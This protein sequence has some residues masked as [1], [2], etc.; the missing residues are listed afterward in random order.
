[1]DSLKSYD[2][3]FVY[4]GQRNYVHGTSMTHGLF[5]AVE[6]WALGPVESVQLNV[7]S[8][9]KEQGRYVLF[10]SE[11]WLVSVKKEYNAMFRLQCSNCDYFVELKNRGKPVTIS[12][13][14]DEEKLTADCKIIKHR[15][16]ATLILRPDTPAIN[17]IIALNKKLVNALFPAGGFGRWFLARYDLAWQKMGLTSPA[18]LEIEVIRNIGADNTHSVIKLTGK[19]L[20]SV[21]FSR[22]IQS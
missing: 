1:M 12:E 13:P 20:G 4:L 6:S 18:L 11:A 16:S 17:A 14:Y 15:K 8:P 22:K 2:A 21:Y 5:K 19:P 9:L 7:H 3:T 10:D